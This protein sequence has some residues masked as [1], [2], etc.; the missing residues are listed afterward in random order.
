MIYL[1]LVLKFLQESASTTTSVTQNGAEKEAASV[2]DETQAT[3]NNA[4][5]DVQAAGDSD[6]EMP[7]ES[8]TNTVVM[9]V[10]EV[11]PN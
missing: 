2:V 9:D 3:A 10:V 5:E 6:V 8:S 1:F 7:A 4:N 11:V